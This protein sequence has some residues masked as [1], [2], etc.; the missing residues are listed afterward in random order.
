MRF[1]VRILGSG[2][3]TPRADRRA[4]AL[5]VETGEI[6]L[7]DCGPG[8]PQALAESGIDYRSL[9]GIFF[10]HHHPDHSLGLGRLLAAARNDPGCRPFPPLF[11]PAGLDDLVG[12]WPILFPG[13]RLGDGPPATREL[14]GGETIDR[15]AARIGCAAADHGDRPALAYRVEANGASMVYTGDTALTDAVVEL[16]AGADLLVAECSAPDEAPLDGHMTPA[17][18]AALAG[19]AGVKRLVATHLYPRMEEFDVARAIASSWD[20]PVEVARD[21]MIVDL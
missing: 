13:T 14:A 10:T 1:R 3:I 8:V 7:F 18:V 20:G 11:G 21:G 17:A 5:T 19:R 6:L 12:G 9:A 4:P 2:T 15:G 16:A